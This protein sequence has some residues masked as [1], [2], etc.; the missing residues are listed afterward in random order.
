MAKS[1]RSR[2]KDRAN[3]AF[4][5]FIRTRDAIRTTNSL[6][7]FE[8]CTCHRIVPVKGNDCGHFVPGRGDGVLYEEHNA[9]GQCASCN[10]FKSGMWVEHEITC[11]ELYGEEEVQ[12]LKQ[13]KFVVVKYKAYDF[14][15]IAQKYKDKQKE[16]VNEFRQNI[17]W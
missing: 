17:L 4:S 5:L 12:R 3:E 13:Q 11:I 14:R 1:E 2:A 6:D 8:C 10:R 16:Q 15:E 9:H 7:E